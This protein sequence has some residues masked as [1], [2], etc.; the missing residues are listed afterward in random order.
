MKVQASL[1][2]LCD[3]CAEEVPD[4]VK[5]AEQWVRWAEWHVHE[6]GHPIDVT[7][8]FRADEEESA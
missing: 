7:I 1:G 3:G 5:T 4:H 8:R 6:T 2:L